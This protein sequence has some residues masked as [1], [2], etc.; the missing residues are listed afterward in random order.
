[1][2]LKPKIHLKSQHSVAVGGRKKKGITFELPYIWE[3]I[4]HE[5]SMARKAAGTEVTR[6]A[7]KLDLTLPS[8]SRAWPTL[9]VD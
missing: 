4:P 3:G 9:T 2:I 6:C 8:T 1:M 7:K 5:D